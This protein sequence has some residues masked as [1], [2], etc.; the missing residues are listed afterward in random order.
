MQ[1]M[2]TKPPIK[3]PPQPIHPPVIPP[4]PSPPPGKPLIPPIPPD[5]DIPGEPPDPGRPPVEPPP[6]DREP[7]PPLKMANKRR[8]IAVLFH[9]YPRGKTSCHTT[10]LVIS[11]K[12]SDTCCRSMP[13][14]YTVQPSITPGI[15]IRI[16]PTAGA[17]PARRKPS[18]R[19]PD[20]R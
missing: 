7:T 4:K 8:L 11:R 5:G 16:P 2:P 14:K 3:E 17:M 1:D 12:V 6:P 19:W 10:H 18:T 9:R 20:Q 13:R 15:P